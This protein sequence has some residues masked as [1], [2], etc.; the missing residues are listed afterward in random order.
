MTQANPAAA[1]ATSAKA[2]ATATATATEEVPLP[3]SPIPPFA[4]A[5]TNND[6]KIEWS[7]AQAV[8]VPK[9]LFDQFDFDKNGSLSETEWL[10]VRLHMTDFTP[11]KTTTAAPAAAT[12][13]R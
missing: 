1:G 5:D 9:K 12:R 3:K 10:F 13:K 7:E 11:P 4:K 2:A 6:G 8:K